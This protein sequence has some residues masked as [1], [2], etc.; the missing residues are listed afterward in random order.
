MFSRSVLISLGAAL[1]L[2][3]IAG[4][5][6]VAKVATKAP[7]PGKQYAVTASS[8]AFFKYGPQ[9]GNG[10]DQHLAKDTLLTVLRPSFGYYKVQLTT[11]EEG[12]V[13][14]EDVGVASPT[15]IAAA[16]MP[17]QPEAAPAQNSRPVG[18]QFR[19]DSNDPR[20]VP[21][22]EALPEPGSLETPTP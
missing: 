20:L 19:L 1:S 2:C 14:A 13:A 10:A 12:Y 7:T 18:E 22:P 9:Q 15:L 21:P 3:A 6:T 8:T 16:Q 5:S 11:G 17:S 4:C